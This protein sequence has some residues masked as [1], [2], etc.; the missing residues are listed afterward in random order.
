MTRTKI[1]TFLLIILLITT[2]CNFPFMV[3]NNNDDV[4]DAISA[5]LQAIIAQTQTAEADSIKPTWTP[6]PTSTTYP[7]Q[8]NT[9]PPKPSPEP[10]NQAVFISETVA[11]GTEFSPGETFEKSWRLKNTG[12]CTW[13]PDYMLDFFSGDRM[14]GPKY[15]DLDDYVKPGETTDIVIELTAPDDPDTYTGYWKLEDDKGEPFY[16]V[17]AQIDVEETF[18]VTSVVL[19]A[20]PESY[21]GACPDTITVDVEADITASAAGKVTYRWETSNGITSDTQ[22]VKFSDADTKTINYD[23][24]IDI[25]ADETFTIKL[26]IDKPNHQ[27]FGPLE[28]E[29]DCT[30]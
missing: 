27:T 29:V 4:D 8:V 15:Q 23:W 2:S 12:T 26:Y 17:Y 11:D 13:N 10:C 25:S 1:L 3:Q 24:D 6:L 21:S 7:T 22:S 19:D 5:T 14:S 20:N 30:P 9:T 28:F 16:Q 18:A